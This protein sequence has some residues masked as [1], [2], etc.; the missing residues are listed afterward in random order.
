MCLAYTSEADPHPELRLESSEV[1]RLDVEIFSELALVEAS[2][3]VPRERQVD[4]ALPEIRALAVVEVSAEGLQ[5]SVSRV[6]KVKTAS[7]FSSVVLLFAS[8]VPS[9]QPG[10]LL[11]AGTG[12]LWVS[13]GLALYTGADYL[14]RAG[15]GSWK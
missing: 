12:L 8:R 7:Q 15:R 4:V 1:L 13:A 9:L 3:V 5:A 14:L 10:L 2:L 6:A 11:E